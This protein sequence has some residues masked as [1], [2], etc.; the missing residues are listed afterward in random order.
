LEDL[1]VCSVE[2][3]AVQ[4][5][6]DSFGRALEIYA[7]TGATWDAGRARGRLRSLGVR[8]RVGSLRRPERGWA[9]LTDSEMAVA[10]LVAEGLTNRDV[11]E[12][13]FISPHTV[14]GHLR[15][16]FLKLNVKT[17]VELARVV[18][19]QSGQSSLRESAL[20][21]TVPSAALLADGPRQAGEPFG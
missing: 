3:G 15:N 11:A 14:S 4:D 1:G 18:S 5:G 13:L 17:R 6:I 7:E 16:I 12:R 10:R 21:S 19:D 8:R 2:G 20:P 9:S